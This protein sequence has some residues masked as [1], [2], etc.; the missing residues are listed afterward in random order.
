[1]E[2]NYDENESMTASRQRS[3]R[4]QFNYFYGS[5]TAVTAPPMSVHNDEQDSLVGEELI[6]TDNECDIPTNGDDDETYQRDFLIDD[7]RRQKRKRVQRSTK[8]QPTAASRNDLASCNS[9]L[10]FLLMA[11]VLSIAM[12]LLV[13]PKQLNM[14][15][16]TQSF[17]MPFPE[18]DRADFGDPIEGFIDMDLFASRLILDDTAVDADENDSANDA[19]NSSRS[20][21]LPFPTGA[22]WTNL[23][24]KPPMGDIMSYPVAVYPF[25]YRWS[26]SS[27][28][29]SYPFGNRMV[30]EKR[31]QDPFIPELTLTTKED[32]IRR[33]VVDYDPLSVTL[34]YVSSSLPN[35]YWE[36]ALVQGN[37]Y[38]TVTYTKQ[39]PILKPRSIFSD[40][41]C[42]GDDDDDDIVDVVD[43][44][45]GEGGREMFGVCRIDVRTNC[46]RSANSFIVSAYY[47][48]TAI[49]LCTV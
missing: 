45:G 26:P 48:T 25:A 33:H 36:T 22:F 6:T 49:P 46:T 23:V 29:V 47:K 37:P 1:M 7:D 35:A 8:S 38:V 17:D 10:V 16:Q 4:P 13:Q 19:S 39:T 15:P 40:V 42:P 14:K 32:T 43:E 20:F 34:R 28:Q 18:V 41:Q 30:E 27:L 11:S 24:V 12:I 3:L 31:I 44:N 21:S 9:I 2:N 5:T